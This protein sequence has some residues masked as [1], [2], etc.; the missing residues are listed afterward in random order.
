MQ[1]WKVVPLFPLIFS[2]LNFSQNVVN[3]VNQVGKI[4]IFVHGGVPKGHKSG[5]LPAKAGT[6]LPK[7][8]R[9]SGSS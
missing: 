3:F 6:D 8:F 7:K 4:P 1:K 2:F 5:Q 9:I